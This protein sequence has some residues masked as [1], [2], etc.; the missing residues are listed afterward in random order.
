MSSSCHKNLS[1]S[2]FCR[3]SL[4]EVEDLFSY[5]RRTTW[6][7]F[8]FVFVF[9]LCSFTN[10]S[11]RIKPATGNIREPCGVLKQAVKSTIKAAQQYVFLLAPIT[12]E[13]S[14]FP[15]IFTVISASS[16]PTIPIIGERKVLEDHSNTKQL[17]HATKHNAGSLVSS[18]SPMWLVGWF[19]FFRNT[20]LSATTATPEGFPAPK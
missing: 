7:F 20:V 15:W 11:G 6:C 12:G 10:T 1:P 13:V 2:R 18:E 16:S 8:L 3:T 5:N 19:F 17:N 4:P 14:T 9:I